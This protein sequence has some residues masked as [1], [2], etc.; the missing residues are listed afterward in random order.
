MN[1]PTK[2]D[3]VVAIGVDMQNDFCPG[4]ALAVTEGDQVVEPFNRAAQW[5][6]DQG[7]EVI[8]TRDWHPANTAHF[9]QWPPHCVA[10]TPGAKFRDGLEV[11]PDDIVVSKGTGASEDAYS[12]FEGKDAQGRNLAEIIFAGKK[13]KVAVV[14][15]GLATDYCVK[16][17]ALDAVEIAKR[18]SEEA[19]NAVFILEDAVRAV[20][21]QPE[22]GEIA[23][24]NMQAAGVKIITSEE[25]VGGQ[26]VKV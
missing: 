7:G 25:L 15:G 10:G 19:Q 18:A 21:L 2:F 8:F 4:G 3:R 20:K 9:D 14:I 12:G 6:R 16:S 5:V 13:E 24:R 22:D 23:I 26:V 17:T 1:T 11:L